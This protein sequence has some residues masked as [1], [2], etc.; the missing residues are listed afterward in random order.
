MYFLAFPNDPRWTQILVYGVY[1]SEFTQTI[2]ITQE[3]F[4]SFALGFGNINAISEEG[5]LWF[6]VPIMSSASAFFTPL[7]ISRTLN[8]CFV[9]YN[10]RLCGPSVLCS[11]P[12]NFGT[13]QHCAWYHCPGET[14]Q[15]SRLLIAI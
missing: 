11:S 14:Y 13:I 4:R 1:I 6:S 2:L 9:L 3:A 5:N 12:P 15:I 10:S 8:H 7:N